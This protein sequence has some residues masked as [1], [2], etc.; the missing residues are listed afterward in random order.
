MPRSK[1]PVVFDEFY[2][3]FCGSRGIPVARCKGSEREAGHLKK[4]FCLKCKKETNHVEC[5]P[6]SKYTHKDF[7]LEFNNHNFDEKGNRINTYGKLK[8]L[9]NNEK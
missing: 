3:V 5:K 4:I 9:I 6:F 2:C 1:R 7:L 8:E